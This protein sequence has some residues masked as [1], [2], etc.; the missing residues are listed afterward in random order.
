MELMLTT[1]ARAE[2]SDWELLAADACF[3]NGIRAY[4]TTTLPSAMDHYLMPSSHLE[5]FRNDVTGDQKIP[6]VTRDQKI[7]S[8][9]IHIIVCRLPQ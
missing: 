7:P 9:N 4:R 2:P 8:V 6:S 3:S 5:L 1:A